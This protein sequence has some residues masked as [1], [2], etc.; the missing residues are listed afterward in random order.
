MRR[1]PSKWWHFLLWDLDMGIVQPGSWF[2]GM[3]YPARCDFS[4]RGDAFLM[5][6][7]KG[8]NDPIA[9]TVVSRPPSVRADVFWPQETAA[10]G[11]GLFDARLPI[12]WLNLRPEKNPVDIRAKC[13]YDFGYLDEENKGYGGLR[14][15]M[16]RDGWSAREISVGEAWGKFFADI[17][18][19]Q[20][21]APTIT[22]WSAK[23]P[24]TQSQLHLEHPGGAPVAPPA[25]PPTEDPT[26]RCYFLQPQG[27]DPIAIEGAVWAGWNKRGHVC[28][29]SDGVLHTAQWKSGN[30]EHSKVMDLNGLA[31]PTE[32]VL[33]ESK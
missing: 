32:R 9:W 4:P 16:T 10:L 23:I 29:L 5:V 13:V 7:Y 33:R 3:I 28:Y 22:R 17:S 26:E 2:S 14:E 25:S 1:G 15:R 11:G 12:I 20:D 27:H 31:P 18:A 21:T 8:T 30:L 19:E 24:G 6:A